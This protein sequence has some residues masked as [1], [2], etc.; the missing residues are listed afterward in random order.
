[1]LRR[2]LVLVGLSAG[3]LCAELLAGDD[4]QTAAQYQAT[5]DKLI[6]AALA[7]D[8]GLK[9]LEY[10]CYRIGNRLSGTQA[11]N[12]AISWSSAEMKKAGLSNV[13]TIPVKVPDW[14][15]GFEAASMI[16]P[17]R[18]PLFMLGLGGSVG[19]PVAGIVAEVVAV[20]SFDELEKLGRAGVAGKIVVYDV[21]FVSYDETV[22]YRSSGASR[23]AHFGAVAAL[24]RSITPLSLR[25]PHTGAMNYSAADPKI[26]T[27]ALSVEDAIYLHKLV[28]SGQKVRVHLT[29]SARTLPDADSADV[30]AEITG[31]EKPNEVVVIGGHLDSWDVGQ[32]AHDDGG[33]AMA[34]LEAITLMKK[35]GLQ[36]R[37]TIRVVLWTN[38]ENGG[39]GGAAYREW[40]KKQ[41]E[42]HFAALEMDGGAE[43][44]IGFDLALG[45]RQSRGDAKTP[46]ALSGPMFDHAV[47]I[48]HL[49]KRIGAD[50][51]IPGEGEADISP[52]MR[53]GVP[54]FGLRTVM[55]HYFDY[56][57][58][59]ADT[60]D[61]I[62][63]DEFRRCAATMAVMS[64][65][66][67]DWP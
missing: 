8:A 43:S 28:Q 64:Y 45:E 25:D 61:K 16:T 4:A 23:A 63:P 55:T 30:M 34:A 39:R 33:G 29:M 22:V 60:F 62:V 50:Q 41:G 59:N 48:G 32:G 53:D 6:D 52:L 10:L 67:A 7:S 54:G 44:P 56:H 57:H 58:T 38:E 51:V 11:L 24:V 5:A 13:R 35:L 37:R 3:L 26:P 17:L 2:A 66:L 46:P 65:V 42:T 47:A 49:L 15:R 14:S 12:E 1:M 21:P 27:A 19:T 40:S 18:K 36:P 20:S 9:Q 31:R